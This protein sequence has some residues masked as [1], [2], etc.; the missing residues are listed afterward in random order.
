[1]HATHFVNVK[2]PRTAPPKRNL[3]IKKVVLD[4]EYRWNL[5]R[6]RVW[7]TRLVF[8]GYAS[9]LILAGVYLDTTATERSW[10]L[11]ILLYLVGTLCTM[12]G[13]YSKKMHE[14]TLQSPPP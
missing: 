8:F 2:S 13:I 1:M 12:A 11:S 9:L 6:E 3:S 7:I 4:S 10:Y 5:I 14:L